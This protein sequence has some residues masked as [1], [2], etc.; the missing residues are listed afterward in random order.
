MRWEENEVRGCSCGEPGKIPEN[1]G[2]IF[3]ENFPLI[4]LGNCHD[5]S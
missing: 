2:N 5:I 4:Q 3:P 1:V